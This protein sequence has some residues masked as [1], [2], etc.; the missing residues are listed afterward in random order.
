MAIEEE[1]D[2]EDYIDKEINRKIALKRTETVKTVVKEC[3]NE[4]DDILFKIKRRARA[5][6]EAMKKFKIDKENDYNEQML[7]EDSNA[8]IRL[9]SQKTDNVDNRL[10]NLR[11]HK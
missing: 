6:Q 3:I 2:P 5:E 1:S 8:N 7:I 11:V 9:T 4:N 10:A